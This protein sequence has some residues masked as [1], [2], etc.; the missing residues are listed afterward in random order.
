MGIF[1]PS[2]EC[3]CREGSGSSLGQGVGGIPLALKGCCQNLE[4]LVMPPGVATLCEAGLATIKDVFVS[5]RSWA[6]GT[7]WVLAIPLVEVFW[8]WEHILRSSDDEVDV[9][10]FHFLELPPAEFSPLQTFPPGPLSV[11]GKR[12][13]LCTYFCLLLLAY[14][15]EHYFPPVFY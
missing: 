1:C 8:R 13:S 12:D 5:R 14:L 9:A 2:D 3:W 7:G 6:E 10:C 4:D 15:L 11:L